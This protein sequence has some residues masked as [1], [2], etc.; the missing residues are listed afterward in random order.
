MVRTGIV[1]LVLHAAGCAPFVTAMMVHAPNRCDEMEDKPSS[2]GKLR[3][4]GV[5]RECRVDVGPPD[6]SLRVW[7]IEPKRAA[8]FHERGTLDPRGTI[9][10]LHGYRGSMKWI[11]GMGRRFAKAGYRVVLFDMRGHGNSSGQYITYGIVEA[12][13]ASQTIDWIEREGL[14]AGRLGV[15]GISMGGATAI[16][17]AAD[18]PR[19]ASVVAVAPYTSMR[20]VV[21][22]VVRLLMPVGGW[23]MSDEAIGRCVDDAAEKAGFNPD[24]ADTCAALRRVTIPTLI[25][26]GKCDWIVP[27]SHGRRLCEVNPSHSQV[28]EIGWTGHI[29]SHFSA[30]VGRESIQWFDQSLR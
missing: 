21:P 19:V 14:L 2:A 16:R 10:M 3:R 18:D 9:L 23:L 24:E 1:I 11:R 15:W 30:A 29:M 12:R 20:E 26:H 17:L 8:T 13:D 5:D 6:A 28:V 25:V 22:G 27:P 4:L 7:V